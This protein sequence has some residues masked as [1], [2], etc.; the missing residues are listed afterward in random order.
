MAWTTAG[1]DYDRTSDYG[2]GANGILD[3]LTL[4]QTQGNGWISLD[5]TAAV[6]AWVEGGQPNHGLLLRGLDGEYTYHYFHSHE[7]GTASLRPG[8]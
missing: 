1:G 5:A 4:P 7:Q 6:R 8:W 2:H 3:Q